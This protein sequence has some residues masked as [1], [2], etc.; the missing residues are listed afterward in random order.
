MQ[1]RKGRVFGG[2]RT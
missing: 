2:G 1:L